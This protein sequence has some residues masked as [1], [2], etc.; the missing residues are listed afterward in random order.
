MGTA[1]EAAGA[2]A[3]AEAGAASDALQ[4]QP[5]PGAGAGAG[6]LQ[7]MFGVG[8]GTGATQPATAPWVVAATL[9]PPANE[10]VTAWPSQQQQQQQ[11]HLQGAQ[12]QSAPSMQTKGFPTDAQA[13]AKMVEGMKRKRERRQEQLGPYMWVFPCRECGVEF[14]RWK[15]LSDH[16]KETGERRGQGKKGMYGETRRLVRG[17][18][19]GNLAIVKGGGARKGGCEQGWRIV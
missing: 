13:R 14:E 6:A 8:A 19:E 18:K 17:G 7:G 16:R 2:T 9:H 4:L 12:L 5:M 3:G 15:K 11:Q 1:V 10:E